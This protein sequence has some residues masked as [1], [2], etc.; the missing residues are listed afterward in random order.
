[1]LHLYKLM[2]NNEDFFLH[3]FVFMS[4]KKAL[5]RKLSTECMNNIVSWLGR[6]LDRLVDAPE[7]T[8]LNS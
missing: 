6:S 1:M 5:R 7:Q 8:L 3:L 2:D 4:L